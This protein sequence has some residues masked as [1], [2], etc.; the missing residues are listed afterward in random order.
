M[1]KRNGGKKESMKKRGGRRKGKKRKIKEQNRPIN[2][3]LLFVV[4]L[5]SGIFRSFSCKVVLDSIREKKRGK[6]P[7]S[8]LPPRVSAGRRAAPV[9]ASSVSSRDSR[10]STSPLSPPARDES[11]GERDRRGFI[12]ARRRKTET[13]KATV[14]KAKTAGCFAAPGCVSLA[15]TS[16]QPRPGG[17]FPAWHEDRVHVAGSV[18][19]SW[20]GRTPGA[21]C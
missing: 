5:D 11:R 17:R 2:F 9:G 10:T 8:L 18:S 15:P 7:G 6:S 19:L 12:A 16:Q 14:P 4:C 3:P 20:Q 1:E 21:V 13:L